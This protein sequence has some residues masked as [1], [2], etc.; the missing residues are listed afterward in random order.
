M[1]ISFSVFRLAHQTISIETRAAM[2]WV[3]TNTP[4]SSQFAILTG[5]TTAMCDSI[6]EWFPAISARTS[7]T[8]A[9]GKEWIS[10]DQFVFEKKNYSDLQFCT[11]KKDESCVYEHLNGQVFDY[12]FLVKGIKSQ[13]CIPQTNPLPTD[14]LQLSLLQSEEWSKVYENDD[15]LIFKQQPYH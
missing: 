5:E 14:A 2:E 3:K 1:N 12:L 13:Y 4:E 7:L 11:M 6:Q 8:T 10:G 15:V 9:Q